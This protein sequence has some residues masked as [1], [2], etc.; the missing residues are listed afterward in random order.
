MTSPTGDGRGSELSRTRLAGNRF[1][2]VRRLGAGGMG[3]VYEALDRD[4]GSAVALKTLTH[5][6]PDALYRFKKEFRAHHELHHPNLVSLGELIAEGD[7]WF[8]TM[9]LVCG[10]DF[11]RYV[12]RDARVDVPDPVSPSA[13]TLQAMRVGASASSGTVDLQRLR[14]A[15]RQ[16]AIG[17]SALH[18]AGTI[19]RDIKPSNVLVDGAGR[20]VIVDFGLAT[21]DRD[22]RFESTQ[23]FVGTAAYMAPE[24]ADSEGVGPEADWYA[25][26]VMLYEAL[27]GRLPFDGTAFEVLLAKRSQ[28]P[29]PP[30]ELAPDVP[31]DLSSLCRALLCRAPSQRAGLDEIMAV[32]GIREPATRP[33]QRASTEPGAQVFG[34]DDELRLLS[35]AAAQSRAGQLV[36]VLLEGEAGVGKTTVVRRFLDLLTR[37]H[38]DVVV[39]AG[40]CYERESVPYKAFDGILDALTRELVHAPLAEAAA[41]VPV[42]GSLLAQVFPVLCRVEAFA[43]APSLARVAAEPHEQR[44]RLFEAVRELF[45][46]LSERRAVVI[47]IDDMQWADAESLALLRVLGRA[48]DAPACL[49]VMTAR[50]GLNIDD[51]LPD[52]RHI[53]LRPL[54]SADARQYAQTLLQDVSASADVAVAIADE[55][56]GHPLFIDALARYVTSTRDAVIANVRLEDVLWQRIEGLPPSAGAL[57]E[58][59]AVAGEPIRQHVAVKAADLATADVAAALNALRS[60][61]LIK[62]D[63]ARAD[64][65]IEV[66]HDRIRE[67]I[68][69]RVAADVIRD[70]HARVAAAL[71]TCDDSKPE[72]LALHWQAAGQPKR[73]AEYARNAGAAAAAALAFDKAVRFYRAALEMGDYDAQQRRSLTIRLAEALAAAGRGAEAAHEF[74]AAASDLSAEEAL[75]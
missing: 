48:P 46:R 32:V 69:A 25:V 26:G 11:L 55:A 13:D 9:E 52:V 39:L 31:D 33:S 67:T 5:I 68:V 38:P 1:T 34:R 37:Q 8:L 60:T 73:A 45:V 41:M 14:D 21:P 66:F 23:N 56:A 63:G 40:R 15:L 3:V 61:S 22:A 30:N 29:V 70:R 58:V 57:L 43:N 6:T 50:G 36:T 74:F 53:R 4:S 51:T 18:R 75:P 28:D 42:M 64:D 20:V 12:R 27:T 44:R 65:R 47:A 35:D 71:E 54:A 17:V 10:C 2:I 59:V 7:E 72:V 49:I 62:T 24:Q 16:L 19:H